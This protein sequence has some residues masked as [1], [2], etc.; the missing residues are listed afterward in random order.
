MATKA[1]SISV[2]KLS[3]AAHAAA[4]AALA[5]AELTTVQPEPGL[6]YN[7]PWI[8]GIIFRNPDNANFAKYQ[9]VSA[10]VT[11]ELNPQPLPPGFAATYSY[12]HV[13]ICGF[14]PVEAEPVVLE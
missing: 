12:D 5:R 13:I 1:T 10:H 4:K 7:F 2:A 3:T 6:I 14:R 9:Q 11:N 8:I